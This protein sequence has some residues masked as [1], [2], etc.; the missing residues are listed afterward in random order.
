MVYRSGDF[1]FDQGPAP[2]VWPIDEQ[3]GEEE[4][5]LDE[6][7]QARMVVFGVNDWDGFQALLRALLPGDARGRDNRGLLEGDQSRDRMSMSG[8]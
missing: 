6:R 2:D 7:M 5:K 8:R 3:N 4:M 1:F